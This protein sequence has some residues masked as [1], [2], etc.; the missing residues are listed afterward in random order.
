METRKS[1]CQTVQHIFGYWIL[2]HYYVCMEFGELI[3]C[4]IEIKTRNLSNGFCFLILLVCSKFEAIRF[5]FS[6]SLFAFCNLHFRFNSIY[7]FNILSITYRSQRAFYKHIYCAHALPLTE[8]WCCI[9]CTE[10]CI[11]D[12]LDIWVF[13]YFYGIFEHF[14]QT[15]NG[16]RF[17]FVHRN[18]QNILERVHSTCQR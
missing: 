15:M 4:E 5:L 10:M 1:Q 3:K 16:I 8:N 7:L 9:R 17:F 13:M 18:L 12:K 6:I 2:A 11:I 14:H